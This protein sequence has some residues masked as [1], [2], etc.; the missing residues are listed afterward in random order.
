MKRTLLAAV[1][2]MAVLLGGSITLVFFMTGHPS[3][4]VPPPAPVDAPTEASAPPKPP[5][6]LPPR[7]LP[8]TG[9]R[10]ARA[11]WNTPPKDPSAPP[12]ASRVIH[13]AVR[14]ALLAAPVQARLAGC[15]DR[16]VG[17]GGG[18]ASGRIP[19]AKPA[20]LVLEMETHAG[21][22]R[23][24]EAQVREWGGASEQTVACARSVLR[25]MVI[26]ASIAEPGQ[27]VGMPWP[28][29]PR[30]EVIAATR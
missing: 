4:A 27:R 17:F 12:M 23:I 13:K 20:T 8:G 21:E 28:L 29:N 6:A 9:T 16:D 11:S 2:G 25:G 18:A 3:P 7:G 30:S 10:M 1:I 26:R 15:V 5:A 22:V 14:K 19:R 24:V